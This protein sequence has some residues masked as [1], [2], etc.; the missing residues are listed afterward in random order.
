M[1]GV[2]CG[3]VFVDGQNTNRTASINNGE[4]A[5]WHYLVSNDLG[6]ERVAVVQNCEVSIFEVCSNTKRFVPTLCPQ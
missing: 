6:V 4:A 3:K 2:N 1:I 5:K